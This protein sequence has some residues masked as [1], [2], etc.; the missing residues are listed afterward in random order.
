MSKAARQKAH[1]RGR[2][3]V[4]N[5]FHPSKEIT[6]P[7]GFVTANVCIEVNQTKEIK[8]WWEWRNEWGA[9]LTILESFGCGCCVEAYKIAAPPKAIQQ[10]DQIG[11]LVEVAD[12]T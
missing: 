10:L 3:S 2:K 6:L 11:L 7:A 4:Y 5:F 1:A 12:Q 9:Q 8:A